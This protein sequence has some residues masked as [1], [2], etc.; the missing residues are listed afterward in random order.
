M[1]IKIALIFLFS[2]SS[3]ALEIY[4]YKYQKNIS[5]DQFLNEIDREA[6]FILGEYHYTPT[7]QK[8]QS[9]II[10]SI[11]T[12]HKLQNHFSVGWEF[13]LHEDQ[14]KIESH[15]LNFKSGL[16]TGEK[17][18]ESLMG[19]SNLTKNLSYL[20]V[21]ETT[22]KFKGEFLGLNAPRTLKR[23]ITSKGL[24]N[25]D[26]THIP[27][28]M[29]LGSANYLNRFKAAM[30]G[31]VDSSVLTKYYEAQCYTD[32]VMAYEL[33]SN[34]NS[35]TRFLLVGAFHS[36]YLD[37]VVAQMKRYSALPTY[38]LK[39]IESSS[40]NASELAILKA[41]DP[42]YGNLADYLFVF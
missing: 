14:A 35:K 36:D 11:V 5:L 12:K 28:N 30:G 8:G 10:E 42:L 39:I 19:K 37:G 20:P 23:I 22:K 1:F 38:G 18:L 41:Y 26:T 7:I 21:F 29:E 32:S 24:K 25:L 9:K 16:L 27:P 3:Y 15:F 4:S 13:L 6:N 31:H 2:F 40:V 33:E 17:L 34:S